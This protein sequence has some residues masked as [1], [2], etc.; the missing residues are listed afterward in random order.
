MRKIGAVILF[1]ICF[2]TTNAQNNQ[3]FGVW[4][5]ISTGYK[6]NKKIKLNGDVQMRTFENSQALK[7]LFVDFSLSYKINKRFKGG[8][9]WRGKES[10]VA[11]NPLFYN[12]FGLDLSW[13]KKIIKRTRLS[14]RSRTQYT[15]VPNSLNK[16]Y[17]RT[18]LK[19]TYKLKKG[20]YLFAQDE[21]FFNLNSGG[22][23]IYDKNRFGL[24]ATKKL[25]KKIDLTAKYLRIVDIGVYRPLTMNVLFVAVSVKI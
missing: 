24:G 5:G 4:T 16:P 2:L 21:L 15:I 18:R 11:I 6:V 3:D 17:E 25:N 7:Q 20:L 8:L 10:Y 12:R 23:P 1:S 13:S 19:L 14:L 22:N 9:S